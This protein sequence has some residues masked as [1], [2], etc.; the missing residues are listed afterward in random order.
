MDSESQDGGT[1]YIVIT[2]IILCQFSDDDYCDRNRHRGAS[3][4][5]LSSRNYG[6][7]QPPVHS[8]RPGPWDNLAGDGR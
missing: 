1:P 2:H 8:S 3:Y 4:G 5:P 6:K 7:S